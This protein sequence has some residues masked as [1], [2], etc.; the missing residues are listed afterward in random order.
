VVAELSG[1]VVAQLSGDV[2]AQLYGDVV[3][4]LSGMWWLSCLRQLGDTRAHIA[5]LNSGLDRE[6]GA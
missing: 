3:A 1:D 4:Q 5:G 2:V 6:V